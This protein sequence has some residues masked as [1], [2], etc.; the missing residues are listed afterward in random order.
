MTFVQTP[1]IDNGNVHEIQFL[2]RNPKGFNGTLECRRVGLV[3]GK[4]T[5]VEQTTALA[6]FFFASF[7][8]GA[9]DPAS[10]LYN[11]RGLSE[12]KEPGGND[13]D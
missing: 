7:R 11:T 8:E 6:S 4:A 1:V 10:E 5:F 13:R 12:S 3:K 2:K 9:I